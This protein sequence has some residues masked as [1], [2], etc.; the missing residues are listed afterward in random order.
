MGVIYVIGGILI[1]LILPHLTS[2][3]VSISSQI[4]LQAAFLAI[5][6]IGFKA[7]ND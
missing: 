3:S 7:F 5:G 4:I 6:F 2:D 1:A